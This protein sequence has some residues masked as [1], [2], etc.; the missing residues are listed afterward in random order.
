VQAAVN[1]QQVILA[2]EITIDSPDFG[3]LEPMVDAVQRELGTAG[4][5]ELPGTVVADPGYWHKLQMEEVVSRGIQVLV[6]PDSGLRKTPPAGMGQRSLRVH[7]SRALNRSRPSCL[8]K[9]DGHCRAGV[10]AAQTQPRIP[11]VHATGR[12]AVRSESQLEADTHKSAEASQPQHRRYR[13]LNGPGTATSAHRA[14]KH[15]RRARR[16]DPRTVYPTATA[17]CTRKPSR[18]PTIALV[19]RPARR[20]ATALTT[21][22]AQPP[23]RPRVPPRMYRGLVGSSRYPM[24]RRALSSPESGHECERSCGRAGRC[25]RLGRRG[26]EVC[27]DRDNARWLLAGFSFSASRRRGRRRAVRRRGA[28]RRSPR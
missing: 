14:V 6:P 3:H 27:Q 16:I 8:P 12:S 21:C 28:S 13:G 4:I 15:S 25:R 24:S 22:I 7:A 19:L 11:T 10:R 17:R 1:E 2:A 9:T 26:G 23:V 5:A 20:R 18:R